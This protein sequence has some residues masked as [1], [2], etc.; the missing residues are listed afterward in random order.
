MPKIKKRKISTKGKK[1]KK[2]RRKKMSKEEKEQVLEK[3][4][5]LGYM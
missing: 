5:A 1:M 4:R 3:L 2:D